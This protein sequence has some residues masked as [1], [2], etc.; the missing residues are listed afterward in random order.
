MQQVV[1]HMWCS[2]ISWS[3]EQKL[4]CDSLTI[5][6]NLICAIGGIVSQFP[7]TP[8]SSWSCSSCCTGIFGIPGDH[9]HIARC[10][11]TLTSTVSLKKNLDYFDKTCDLQFICPATFNVNLIPQGENCNCYKI[12]CPVLTLGTP[13]A[14][15]TR[16]SHGNPGKVLCLWAR[17]GPVIV[18]A[19]FTIPTATPLWPC[20]PNHPPVLAIE[21]VLWNR[22]SCHSHRNSRFLS[23]MERSICVGHIL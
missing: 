21:A 22:A 23:W 15:A 18:F 1:V 8:K 10:S 9:C 14:A 7:S 6:I 17:S 2:L 20:K 16:I 3:D 19:P 4:L 13:K 12:S 5:T 11:G